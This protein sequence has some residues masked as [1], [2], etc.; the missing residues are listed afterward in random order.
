MS[1]PFPTPPWY[2]LHCSLL[3]SRPKKDGSRRL[4]LD[5]SQPMGASINE[6]ISK[7]DFNVQYTH[8]DSATDLVFKKGKNCLMSKLARLITS[9]TLSMDSSRHPLA[10]SV[11]R[12]HSAPFR[13]TVFPW[14]IQ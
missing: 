2:N 5:L 9:I 6:G 13:L 8:F 3:G 14:H 4:I 7:D 12:R 1:G 10:R 11:F